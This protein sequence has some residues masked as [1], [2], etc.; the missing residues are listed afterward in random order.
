MKKIVFKKYRIYNS[1][2]GILFILLFCIYVDYRSSPMNM[3]TFNPLEGFE[4]FLWA[5]MWTLGIIFG[6]I[7]TI[8]VFV[9]LFFS[10]FFL[11]HSIIKMMKSM[12]R[13]SPA[14]YEQ[15]NE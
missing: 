2:A 6:G 15:Q 7:V 13:T 1:I 3:R 14:K 12:C 5:N 8:L 4:S 9:F 11:S 10:G